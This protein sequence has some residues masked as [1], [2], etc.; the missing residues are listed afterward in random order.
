MRINS[1][2]FRMN[3]FSGIKGKIKNAVNG[4][5]K[6]L[7]ETIVEREHEGVKVRVTASKNIKGLEFSPEFLQSADAEGKKGKLIHAINLA[8]QEAE[9]I[10]VSE[11][12][13]AGDGVIPGF[14]KIFGGKV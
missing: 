2:N 6:K 13:T 9:G 14:S 4:T 5:R 12:K 7:D 8:L 3:F 11:L 10:A 1:I